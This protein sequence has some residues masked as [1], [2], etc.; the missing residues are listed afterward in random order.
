VGKP[1]LF[2]LPF[3]QQRFPK[4]KPNFHTIAIIAPIAHKPTRHLSLY[5]LLFALN[6]HTTQ[7]MIFSLR[8]TSSLRTLD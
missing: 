6:A 2:L 1:F 8:F 7:S 5:L 4:K 3:L